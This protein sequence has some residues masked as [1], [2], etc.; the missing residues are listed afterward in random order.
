MKLD[1]TLCYINLSDDLLRFTRINKELINH[2]SKNFEKIYIL[3]LQYLRLFLKSKN[4][5]IRKNK[6]LLPK[7]F[8]IIFFKNSNDF[9]KFSKNK[10]LI[11]IM[12]SLT[13]SCAILEFI[14]Y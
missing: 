6:K 11:V 13:K 10:K 4:F 3:N 5:S 1:K 2:L 8:E 14:I 7:N 12:N 9:L